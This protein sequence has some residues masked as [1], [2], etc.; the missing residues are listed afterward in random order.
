[1]TA[2]LRI[3]G[4]A[5]LLLLTDIWPAAADLYY[6]TDQKGVRHYTNTKPP[7]GENA[8]A[9][10]EELPHDP[11]TEDQRRRQEDAMLEEAEQDA[12]Q[13]RLEEAERKAEEARRQAEAAQRKADRLEQELKEQEEEDRSYGV[14]YPYRWYGPPGWRPP[15]HRPPGHRPPGDTPPAWQPPR[16]RPHDT[17]PREPRPHNREAP[18]QGQAN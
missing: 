8:T 13:E 9:L 18:S 17:S 7:D 16:P 5:M 10:M 6:W 11:A 4:L 12:L 3:A 1:M 2:F 15:G 14:Y